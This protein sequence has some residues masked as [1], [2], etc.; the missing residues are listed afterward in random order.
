MPQQRHEV[1]EDVEAKTSMRA[2]DRNV[3]GAAEVVA[4]RPGL[5]VQLAFRPL[6]ALGRA[7]PAPRAQHPRHGYAPSQI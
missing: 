5:R 3:L 7:A 6:A 4:G 1:A 2:K